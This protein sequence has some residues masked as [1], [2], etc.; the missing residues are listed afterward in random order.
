MAEARGLGNVKPKVG[1]FVLATVLVALAGVF[2]AGRAQG[3]F[4]K[5]LE[6][7]TDAV[8]FPA[9]SDVG[10][11]EGAEVQIL[12]G[13]VGSVTGV[14]LDESALPDIRVKFKLRVRGPLMKL[15]RKDS[16]V[17]V[18]RK[19]GFAGSS[20]LQITTGRGEPYDGK[21]ELHCEI[22]PDLM[23]EVQKTL[24]NFNAPG[25]PV[26]KMLANASEL[27]SN[28]VAGKGA[29]GQLLSDEATGKSLAATL[30]NVQTLTA[31]LTKG[32]GSLG[33]LLYD[34]KTGGQLAATMGATRESVENINKL[35]VKAQGVDVNGMMDQ[36]KQTLGGVDQAL[37]EVSL[38][39][40][41][42]RQ[43]TKDLPGVIA[44]TQE[45]M[46][47]TTRTIEGMQKTW[48]LRDKVAA[49]GSTRLAPGD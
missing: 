12:G 6:V 28:L 27:S 15:V 1:T 4:E 33:K 31:N 40:A 5:K 22:P 34:D 19:F 39:T 2:L 48:L 38:A 36:I 37:K 20:Y 24:G 9:D 13:T 29:A 3:W 49:E 45:M 32:D 16:R 8:T 30:A 46:R 17:E 44:Q 35:L 21:T 18:R 42:L 7:A 10:M 23:A 43:Q 47:Q 14:T 25:S 41:Q 11:E 26:Q